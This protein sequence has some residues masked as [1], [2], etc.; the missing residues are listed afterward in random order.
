MSIAM[1]AYEVLLI[2]FCFLKDLKLCKI[3]LAFQELTG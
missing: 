3:F 2:L 1:T